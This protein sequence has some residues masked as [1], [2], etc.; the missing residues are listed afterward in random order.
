MEISEAMLLD[1]LLHSLTFN[2]FLVDKSQDVH[3]LFES[4]N[5]R[6]K[7]LSHLEL[8]KSR[9]IYLSTKMAETNENL[10][11]QIHVAWQQIYFYLDQLDRCKDDYDEAYLKDHFHVYFGNQQDHRENFVVKF[12]KKYTDKNGN[13]KEPDWHEILLK[14]IFPLNLLH[15]DHVNAPFIAQYCQSLSGWISYWV[16]LKKPV[17]I[18]NNHFKHIQLEER[19][20]RY[21][22]ALTRLT[23]DADLLA[24]LAVSIEEMATEGNAPSTKQELYAFSAT[25]ALDLCPKSF[26]S[27]NHI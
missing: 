5:N 4:I 16:L 27:K 7:P 13:A 21:I 10:E 8:L 12:L 3:T 2:L 25:R 19:S 26:D 11:E 15:H 18:K 17:L 6:G 24:L 23:R 9:L 22:E 1:K 14:D 20:W